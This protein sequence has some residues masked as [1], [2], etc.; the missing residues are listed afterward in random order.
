MT[1]KLTCK[2]SDGREWDVVGEFPSTADGYSEN[3]VVWLVP[4][5]RKP[6]E[7]YTVAWISKEY[8][9]MQSEQRFKSYVEA[10]KWAE[11]EFKFPREYDII[12]VREVIAE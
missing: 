10:M 8:G 3:R 5:H 11:L 12:K 1:D 4:I 7:W 2:M 6:R 9:E